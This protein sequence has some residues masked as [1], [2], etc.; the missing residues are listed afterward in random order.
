[1]Q[2]GLGARVRS[3]RYGNFWIASLLFAD[4]VVL[5]ASGV[6]GSQDESWHLR[7]LTID[8]AFSTVFAR[9]HSL[10]LRQWQNSDSICFSTTPKVPSS[11]SSEPEGY[12]IGLKR[13]NHIISCI[14][15]LYIYSMSRPHVI[16][17]LLA[18][19]TGKQFPHEQAI[20]NTCYIWLR[21]TLFLFII[22]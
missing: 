5:L 14:K 11:H 6:W 19:N 22:I 12:N 16:V 3:V 20:K 15:T 21:P 4:D 1:M 8:R 18:P 10:L 17:Y 7:K 9:T 2:P 13:P